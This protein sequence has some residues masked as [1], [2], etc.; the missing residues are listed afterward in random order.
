ML[1][2]VDFA[3]TAPTELCQ[4]PKN[5]LFQSC[6]LFHSSISTDCFSAVESQKSLAC[7]SNQL[8]ICAVGYNCE[9]ET[10]GVQCL[11][12]CY[13]ARIFDGRCLDDDGFTCSITVSGGNLRYE[14]VCRL[15]FYTS[16]LNFIQFFF[17]VSDFQTL[18]KPKSR[19]ESMD[20]F[21]IIFISDDKDFT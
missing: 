9:L 8:G 10:E 21:L 3:M 7:L 20:V 5:S 12:P 19:N 1:I 13:I 14:S 2:S 4:L 16:E 6:M 15:V 17:C 18:S 11:H